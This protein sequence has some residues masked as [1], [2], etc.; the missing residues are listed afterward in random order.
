MGGNKKP[1][2]KKKNRN[3]A[4]LNPKPPLQDGKAEQGASNGVFPVCTAPC[5]QISDV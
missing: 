4:H 5:V 2:N 3:V 1:K